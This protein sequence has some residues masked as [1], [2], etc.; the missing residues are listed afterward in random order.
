MLN[1]LGRVPKPIILLASVA[2][3]LVLGVID[4]LTGREYTFSI[5]YLL[6]IA[7][8]AWYVNRGTGIAVAFLTIGVWFAAEIATGSSYQHLA[9]YWNSAVRMSVFLIL[10]YLI[11]ANRKNL[12]EMEAL[13]LSDPLT[14]AANSRYFY[15]IAEHDLAV[16]QRQ[17]TPITMVYIDVDDFKHIND[18]LG[19]AEGDKVLRLVVSIMQEQR[20][21]ADMVVRLGGDEFALYLPGMAQDAAAQAVS[22]LQSTLLEAVQERDYPVTFSIGVV[23]YPVAPQTL[24]EMIDEADKLMYQVKISGKNSIRHFE[25][26]DPALAQNA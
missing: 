20:R 22:Q 1:L 12:Q 11:D 10:L 14:G 8:V 9:P 23:T 19:H 24:Q 6:P 5:F 7:A 17:G 15:K 25:Y 26:P 16:A 3:V 13:A 4:W 18:Q 2:S 21:Q